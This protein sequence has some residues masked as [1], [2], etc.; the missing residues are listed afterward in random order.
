M[1]KLLFVFIAQTHYIEA[2]IYHTY[3]EILQEVDSMARAYPEL[4]MVDTIGYSQEWHQPIIAVKISDNAHLAEPE[5]SILFDGVHHA[6]EVLGAEIIMSTMWRLLNGYENGNDTCRRFVDS[7]QIWFLPVLNP[8][9]HNIVTSVVDTGWRKN[10][11]DNNGNGRFD[12]DYDGVDLNRNYGFHWYDAVERADTTPSDYFYKGPAPFSEAETRAMAEFCRRE[13][14]VVVVNYHSPSYSMGEK[15]YFPWHWPDHNPPFPVDFNLIRE[16]AL[17]M[18]FNIPMDDGTGS[19]TAVYGDARMPNA[20]NWMY[21]TYGIIALT[22]EVCSRRVQIPPDE[23]PVVIEHNQRGIFWLIERM[24][25]TSIGVTVLDSVTGQPL[26]ADIRILEIDTFD[27]FPLHR[28]TDVRT[29]THFRL[30]QSPGTYTLAISAAGYLPETTTVRIDQGTRTDV[31]VRLRPRKVTG[32]A[33]DRMKVY[34][35]APIDGDYHLKLFDVSGRQVRDFLAPSLNAGNNEYEITI[36]GLPYGVYLLD[37]IAPD[38]TPL[39][40][41]KIIHIK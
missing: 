12:T 36:Q 25:S 40:T 20:R 10:A 29:G 21:S 37:L 26:L 14:F 7:L 1:I 19:Y 41:F 31:T 34:F 35:Y 11:R 5:P 28:L 2:P 13:K 18:A 24:L 3:N 17:N 4:V 15:I 30:I 23:V 33:Q 32:A 9:G 27:V 38:K 6:E 8:D 16:I 39:K 22:P